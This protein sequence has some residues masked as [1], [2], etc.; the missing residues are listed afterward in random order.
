MEF[1]RVLFRSVVDI[2]GQDT[3]ETGLVWEDGDA[4]RSMKPVPGTLV[5]TPWGGD[6][7]AQFLVGFYELDGTPHAL[8]PRHVLGRVID[9]FAADGPTP[10]LA[11]VLEFYLVDQIGRAHVLTPVTH[12]HLVCRLLLEKYIKRQF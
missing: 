8:A 2:T 3:I 7:A 5:R 6:R 12:A 11:V 1:R 4:D 10:V 9:R